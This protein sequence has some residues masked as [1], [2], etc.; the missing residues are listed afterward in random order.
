VTNTLAYYST[1]KITVVKSFV[2]QRQGSS[3]F[4]EKSLL[5]NDNLFF[6]RNCG[7]TTLRM[8]TFSITTLSL[9]DLFLYQGTLTE[10]EGSVRL[11]SSIR[12]LVL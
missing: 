7:A 6:S 9:M 11:T 12:Q 8:A 10:G 2:V 1:E 3:S 4:K 5:K